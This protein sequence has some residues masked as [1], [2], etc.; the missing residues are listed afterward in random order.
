[1]FYIYIDSMIYV[2]IY[3]NIKYYIKPNKV[4]YIKS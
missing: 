2:V 3:I 1:M 4:K